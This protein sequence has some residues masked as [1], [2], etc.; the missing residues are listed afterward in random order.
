[1]DDAP[2][3]LVELPGLDT[4]WGNEFKI[5][6]LFQAKLE[7]HRFFF[8]QQHGRFPCPENNQKKSIAYVFLPLET[9]GVYSLVKKTPGILIHVFGTMT[10][11]FQRQKPVGQVKNLPPDLGP[12]DFEE[13]SNGW[14]CCG[15]GL[16]F[17]MHM[18]H[19]VFSWRYTLPETNSSPMKIPSFLVNTIK[20]VG[21]PWLFWFQ[22]VLLCVF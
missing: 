1:M 20:M 9:L 2:W 6:K 13:W 18:S 14:S 3:W 21:F 16:W 17:V 10:H 8:A 5:S 7:N 12:L 4:S 19:V 22:G 11:V 15:C